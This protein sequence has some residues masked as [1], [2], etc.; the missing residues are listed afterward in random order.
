M[1]C[2]TEITVLGTLLSANG[3]NFDHTKILP[4]GKGFTSTSHNILS[5]PLAAFPHN[6]CQ[7]NRQPCEG[8]ESCCNMTIINAQ[9][10]YWPSRE[11]KQRPP[12]LKSATLTTELWGS[13]L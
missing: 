3:L 2:K 10:E 5:K 1:L 4:F 8:N 9:T 11:M 6:H 7:N 13:A 12:L